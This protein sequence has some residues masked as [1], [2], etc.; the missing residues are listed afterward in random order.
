MIFVILRISVADRSV[1]WNLDNFL[2][3]TSIFYSFLS[4]TPIRV[5]IIFVNHPHFSLTISRKYFSC[6]SYMPVVFSYKVFTFSTM[7]MIFLSLSKNMVFMS[8]ISLI[9][10]SYPIYWCWSVMS[11][12]LMF[13][14]G[15][16]ESAC[17][18]G[19]GCG[20]CFWKISLRLE[21]SLVFN[22]YL[23][24]LI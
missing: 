11:W 2:S 21:N 12:S 10:S 15:V 3:N 7:S 4:I 18:E 8:P 5:L 16:F 14:R 13:G 24:S 23:K 19:C 6:C 9:W 1:F 20:Y 22:E 17:W